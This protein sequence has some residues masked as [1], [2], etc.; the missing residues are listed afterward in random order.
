[1][2][3]GE[4]INKIIKTRGQWNISEGEYYESHHILP[5]CLGGLPKNNPKKLKHKNLIWLYPEEHCIA[6]KLLLEKYPGN[7]KLIYA[8]W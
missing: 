8:A 7:A 1:M 3:Y 2:T 4:F 5:K 6:H